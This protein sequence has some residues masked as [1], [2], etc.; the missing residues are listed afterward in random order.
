MR[1]PLR[2]HQSP[3]RD[4]H[5]R[6]EERARCT[7]RSGENPAAGAVQGQGAQ[8]R[9]RRCR[10]RRWWRRRRRAPPP[11]IGESRRPWAMWTNPIGNL[12]RYFFR[13]RLRPWAN[14]VWPSYFRESRGSGRLTINDSTVPGQP[15]ARQRP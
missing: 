14:G 10:R 2:R 15:Y 6:S 12:Q 3:S 7:Q 11:S 5:A 9:G 13:D 8:R 1:S 4:A